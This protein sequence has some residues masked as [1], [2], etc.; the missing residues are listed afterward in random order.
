MKLQSEITI[1]KV[2]NLDAHNSLFSQISEMIQ[3]GNHFHSQIYPELGDPSLYLTDMSYLIDNKAVFIVAL[4]NDELV[5]MG[6]ILYHEQYC[7]FKRVFVNPN[8]RGNGIGKRIILAMEQD[9]ISNGYSK[10]Y[11]VTGTRQCKAI[12]LYQQMGFM[13]M[14]SFGSYQK[15]PLLAF[16]G[17][18]MTQ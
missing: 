6:A 12:Q 5:G 14:E 13:L 3:Q 1:F 18:T 7:E 10:A 11:L 2:V 17:K 9:V 16:L 15:S 8:Q 4:E